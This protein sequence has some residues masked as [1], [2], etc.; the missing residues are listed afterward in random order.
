MTTTLIKKKLTEAIN[1]I[2]D[3][4]FLEALQII[5]NSKKNEESVYQLSASQKKELDKRL[6][7]HKS[8]KSKSYTWTEVKNSL[9]KK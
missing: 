2:N 7:N 5:V 1:E 6:E 8:E 4:D 9:L 3:T